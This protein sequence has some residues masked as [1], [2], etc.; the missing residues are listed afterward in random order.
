M[1]P[2]PVLIGLPGPELDELGREQLRHPAVGGVVLFTR[3]FSSREQLEKLVADIHSTR[4]PDL[5]ICIGWVSKL[6][7]ETF[8]IMDR[9]L[10]PRRVLMLFTT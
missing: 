8:V 2:G 4:D 7:K 5:L 9:Y 6:L 1:N 3:N 10:E